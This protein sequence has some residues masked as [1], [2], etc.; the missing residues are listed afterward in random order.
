MKN[1]APVGSLLCSRCGAELAALSRAGKKTAIVQ[2]GILIYRAALTCPNCNRL[3]EFH[4]QSMA[5]VR[6]GLT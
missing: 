4:S 2:T 6:L 3:T 1:A 5:A